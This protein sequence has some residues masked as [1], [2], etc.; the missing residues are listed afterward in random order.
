MLSKPDSIF[1]LRK[2]NN[3]LKSL[4]FK[5]W[6][7]Y[8]GRTATSG[9]NNKVALFFCHA[10]AGAIGGDEGHTTENY[11]VFVLWHIFFCLP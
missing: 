1:L 2:N 8:N 5:I 3:R 7:V 10:L 9:F 6:F 11:L 4:W